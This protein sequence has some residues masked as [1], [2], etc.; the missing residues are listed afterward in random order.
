MGN[1]MAFLFN[2]SLTQNT[3]PYKIYEFPNETLELLDYKVHK[4]HLISHPK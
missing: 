3:A 4:F 2:S 1:C